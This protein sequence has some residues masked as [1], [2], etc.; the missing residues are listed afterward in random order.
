MHGSSPHLTHSSAKVKAMACFR[1]IDWEKTCACSPLPWGNQDELNLAVLIVGEQKDLIAQ[2]KSQGLSAVPPIGLFFENN[3]VWVWAINKVL[4]DGT[5]DQKE[6]A[7]AEWAW[8]VDHVPRMGWLKK[9]AMVLL[10]P[11]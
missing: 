6:L 2:A 8:S 5:D 11:A 3:H 4:S 9:L 1:T 7:K 10:R